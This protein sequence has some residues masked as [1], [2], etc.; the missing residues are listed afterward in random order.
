M[1]KINPRKKSVVVFLGIIYLLF[2]SA[3][4]YKKTTNNQTYPCYNINQTSKMSTEEKNIIQFQ[5]EI[6]N[7]CETELNFN[8]FQ[9]VTKEKIEDNIVD[10][11]RYLENNVIVNIGENK[12][13]EINYTL[14][15]EEFK[16]FY[17]YKLIPV[18]Q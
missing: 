10:D 17:R 9:I 4:I 3:I 7:S 13:I 5:L 12:V 6:K 2:L 8:K 16:R 1:K 18:E 14:N 15:E 11:S